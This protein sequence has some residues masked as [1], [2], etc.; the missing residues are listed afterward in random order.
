MDTRTR[1]ERTYAR[2][3]HA[4]RQRFDLECA[5]SV[6]YLATDPRV[7]RLLAMRR[8]GAPQDQLEPLRDELY[9]AFQVLREGDDR[10]SQLAYRVARAAYCATDRLYPGLANSDY[11]PSAPDEARNA[12]YIDV[13]R[14][15][16]DDPDAADHARAEAMDRQ[17]ARMDELIAAP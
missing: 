16:R 1:F 12:I 9:A 13:L 4:A 8:A 6:S 11:Y 17:I 7:A 14:K 2:L 3:S 10:D 5:E 15:T